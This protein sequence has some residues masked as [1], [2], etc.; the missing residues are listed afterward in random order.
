VQ[1]T[2]SEDSRTF[3]A[4]LT[5]EQWDAIHVQLQKRQARKSPKLIDIRFGVDL[6]VTR[7]FVVL[8]VGKDR[9]KQQ[10]E[11]ATSKLT[12]VGNITAA[13]LFL[14]SANLLLSAIILLGLYLCKSA[15]G[16]D[17]T[18]GHI[19]ETIKKVL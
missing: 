4:Q 6:I 5:P 19:S 14:I 8:M 7:F 2:L 9:R 3:L 1:E 12:K 16:L 10:R 13:A 15:L 11:N 18:P 17:F